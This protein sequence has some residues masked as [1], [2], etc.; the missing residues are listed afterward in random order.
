MYFVKSPLLFIAANI[1]N[2]EEFDFRVCFSFF[3]LFVFQAISG[4]TNNHLTG[5]SDVSY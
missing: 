2:G 4:T 3:L 5:L 1:E